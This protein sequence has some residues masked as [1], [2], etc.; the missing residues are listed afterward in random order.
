MR[1]PLLALLFM[2]TAGW[3][4]ADPLAPV[5][6]ADAAVAEASAAFGLPQVLIRRVMRQE[7]AGDPHAVS[8]AGAMGLMQLMPQTWAQLRARLALG[9]DPFD[10][11][12][13]IVA[14]AAYLRA[15]LDRFGAPGFL[16]AYNAGPQRYA[17]WLAGR[18]DLPA[19]TAAYLRRL[20]PELGAAAAPPAPRRVSWR[21]AD[22][23][24]PG[25]GVA[26]VSPPSPRSTGD[27]ER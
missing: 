25:V 8:R 21:R 23:F 12:D 22:L 19:E 16:A 17:D 2:T 5:S 3:A 11:H 15:M 13:N 18:A 27:H 14:G 6:E 24:P 4:A 20:A 7:S 26:P 9:P 1:P 10:V